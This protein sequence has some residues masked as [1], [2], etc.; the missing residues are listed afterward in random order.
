MKWSTLDLLSLCVLTRAEGGK[1]TEKHFITLN[2]E[3][4]FY[5]YELFCIREGILK[6]VTDKKDSLRI[7]PTLIVTCL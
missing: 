6:S 2:K 1:R 4:I 5:K 7:K 3:V